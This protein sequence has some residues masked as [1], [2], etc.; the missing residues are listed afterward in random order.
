MSSSHSLYTGTK[1]SQRPVSANE[2]LFIALDR[3]YPPFVNQFVLEGAGF[4]NH[5]DWSEAVRIASEANP[6]S[7]VIL[8]G[9][10]GSSRF[11]DSAVAP[12]V[13]YIEQNQWSGFDPEAADFLKKPLPL[14]SGPSAEVLLLPGEP[15][16]IVIRTH[17]A[18]M[19]GGGTLHWAQDIFNALNNRPLLGSQLGL[20][21]LQVAKSLDSRAEPDWQ[22]KYASPTGD[23]TA[24]GQDVVWQRIQIKSKIKQLLPKVILFIAQKARQS[25]QEKIDIAIPVDMRKHTFIPP[26]TGN[27][28]GFIHVL[29]DSAAT[30]DDIARQILH[31]L[32]LR[33]FAAFNPALPWCSHIPLSVL[34]YAIK[35]DTDDMCR[36]GLF[37]S[38]AVLSNLG[39]LDLD[40]YSTENF[41]PRS[42]FFIPPG[43]AAS[44]CFIALSGSD[45]AIELLTSMT[46]SFAANGRL[47][48]LCDELKA[49][50]LE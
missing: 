11:V 25:A 45:Y 24:A 48:A 39:K 22:K 8:R 36:R 37:A 35:K 3:L 32:E 46:T 28:T 2:R 6:G 12:V 23:A 16:R 19:D 4:F 5:A 26:N 20:T 14:H 27:L 49:Y 17:H 47:Q 10:L 18:T 50:L 30:V 1:P 34:A 31:K 33:E 21:D 7:R 9:H 15:S 41:K 38:S 42:G 44:P 29:A 13:K 43:N 40:A